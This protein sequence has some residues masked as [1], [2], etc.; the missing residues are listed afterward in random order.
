MRQYLTIGLVLLMA[1]NLNSTAFGADDIAIQVAAVPMGAK[2]DVHLKNRQTLHGTRGAVSDSA[3]TLVN[4]GSTDRQVAFV[5][6]ASVKQAK[7]H[8]LRNV[9]II[10]GVGVVI[11]VVVLAVHIAHCPLGCPA[12][13]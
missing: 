2:V 6:V 1:A 5:D 9:L 13:V 8:T 7:S 10:A 4:G 12:K 11:V 3:F